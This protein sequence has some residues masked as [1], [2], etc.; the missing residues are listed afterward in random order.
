MKK[1]LI[2]EEEKKEPQVQLEEIK[3]DEQE[4]WQDFPI[5]SDIDEP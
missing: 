2:T 4:I 5:D 3:E 1:S